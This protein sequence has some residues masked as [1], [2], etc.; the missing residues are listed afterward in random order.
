[1]QIDVPLI[2]PITDKLLSSRTTHL[3][4]LK[5]LARGGARWVQIRD[6]S[7][8][9]RELLAD[10]QRCVDFA[11]EKGI[12]LIVNDRCDLALI[13]SAVGVH[14]GQTDLPPAAAR[15]ILGRQRLIGFSTHTLA[16]VHAALRLPIDYIGFGPV[17]MSATKESPDR[18]VGIHGLRRACKA[19][20]KPVVAIGG[21][22]H[23]QVRPALDAG[24]SSVAV[25]SALM[26]AKDI[27]R[28]MEDLLQ[29][30]TA[31]G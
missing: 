31:K 22:G 16:Q 30:A 12:R 25:I 2:Y 26:R 23:G 7:T 27:A 4:I 3:A 18:P 24:A 10:L 20:N 17:F 14:L 15:R 6:K 29:E 8:P 5:E 13:A 28:G 1:M 19:S 9:V 11:A 21:I